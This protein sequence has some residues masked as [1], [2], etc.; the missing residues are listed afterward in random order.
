MIDFLSRRLAAALT[1]SAYA[2]D[3]RSRVRS[4]PPS[5]V[6]RSRPGRAMWSC[7]ERRRGREASKFAARRASGSWAAAVAAKVTPSPF[8]ARPLVNPRPTREARGGAVISRAESRAR[9]ARC[10]H[11]QSSRQGGRA[12]NRSER[13]KPS[14]LSVQLRTKFEVVVNDRQG[15]RFDRAAIDLASRRRRDQRELSF[16]AIAHSLL[17]PEATHEVR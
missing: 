12:A 13:E 11:R 8:R 7:A 10:C 16:V 4:S 6:G 2:A 9:S 3:R 5:S 1:T 15:T 17:W 14:E